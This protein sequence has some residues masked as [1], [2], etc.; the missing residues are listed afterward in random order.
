MKDKLKEVEHR[1]LECGKGVV[2]GRKR[3][4]VTGI[5]SS[6]KR[7]DQRLNVSG[8]KKNHRLRIKIILTAITNTEM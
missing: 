1:D 7:N 6:Q 3:N 8:K 5:E 2:L 4:Q